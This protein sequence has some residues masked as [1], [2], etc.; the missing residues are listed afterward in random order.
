MGIE[1]DP[2]ALEL[3]T[4]TTASSCPLLIGE[5][6]DNQLGRA[7]LMCGTPIAITDNSTIFHL[8]FKKKTPGFTNLN[9]LGH[10]S[11]LLANG[12]GTPVSAQLESHNIF[13]VK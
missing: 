4:A 1:F 6:I 13:V 12:H 11:L 8:T 5:F 10:S 3:I 2:Q 7:D 9:F